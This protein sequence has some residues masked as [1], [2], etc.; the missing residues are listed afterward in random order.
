MITLPGNRIEQA[1]R[2]LEVALR[3]HAHRVLVRV[4]VMAPISAIDTMLT[5]LEEMN[6]RGR[7]RVPRN[8]SARLARLVAAVPAEVTCLPDL[9]SN[10]APTRLM[11]GLFELQDALFDL[12]VGPA[13][14]RLL[15]GDER[16]E[17]D[18]A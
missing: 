11:D 14:H 4:R 8:W 2:D 10:I 18:V 6:V 15:A 7:R 12:K 5:E 17:L 16:D 1:G 3:D 9:R 13:R